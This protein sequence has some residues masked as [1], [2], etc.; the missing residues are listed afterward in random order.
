MILKPHWK[1]TKH[2]GERFISRFDGDKET[3]KEIRRYF[4]QNVLQCVFEC[5]LNGFKQRVRIGQ[6]KVCYVWDPDEQM[7][8]ITTVY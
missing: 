3:V 1:F 2:F 8:I 7:I 4:N 5:H 6:Y